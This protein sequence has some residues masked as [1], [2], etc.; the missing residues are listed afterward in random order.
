MCYRRLVIH[1]RPMTSNVQY[2]VVCHTR[3][4]PSP[5]PSPCSRHLVVQ[6]DLDPQT[7]FSP[8]C[9][10]VSLLGLAIQV[11]GKQ[12]G[13]EDRHRWLPKVPG[14]SGPT[15][16]SRQLVLLTGIAILLYRG[17]G[18]FKAASSLSVFL[19]EVRLLNTEIQAW[20]G[21]LAPYQRIGHFVQGSL[22]YSG[23]YLWCR[24]LN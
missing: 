17:L 12:G 11:S 3:L 9:V 1:I 24:P 14:R 18:C 5:H 22:H 19:S 2:D 10:V 7:E 6:V 13:R 21:R 16:L 15:L 4:E 8:R 20:V 23:S